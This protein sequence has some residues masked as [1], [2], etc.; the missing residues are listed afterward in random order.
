MNRSIKE[1]QTFLN[2]L[3]ES[4]EWDVK[5]PSSSDSSDTVCLASLSAGEF[6]VE[7]LRGLA[8]N[9]QVGEEVRARLRNLGARNRMP[10]NRLI[11]RAAARTEVKPASRVL[12]LETLRARLAA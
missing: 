8:A 10:L 11:V 6:L 7:S 2:G 3:I 12:T 1:A 9:E 4:H 5:T